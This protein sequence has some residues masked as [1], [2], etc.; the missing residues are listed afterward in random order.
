[1]KRFLGLTIVTTSSQAITMLNYCSKPAD[2][3]LPGVYSFSA[4]LYAFSAN[5]INIS[6]HLFRLLPMIAITTTNKSKQT[7]AAA[8]EAMGTSIDGS[9]LSS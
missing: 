5:R 7:T 8:A 4:L 9:S 6:T 3:R 2:N 1:M